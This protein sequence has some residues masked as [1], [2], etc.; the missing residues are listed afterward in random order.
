LKWQRMISREGGFSLWIPAGIYT[1]EIKSVPITD[2][3]LKFQVL[4]TNQ[5]N[6]RFIVA[7]SNMLPLTALTNFDQLFEKIVSYI[8]AKTD[9]RVTRDSLKKSKDYPGYSVILASPDETIYLQ[10]YLANN[11]AFILGVN[12][13]SASDLSQVSQRFFESFKVF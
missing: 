3:T 9:F 11:R 4:S 5:P 10:L 7:Y 6:S 1:D 12:Q 2:V 13:K 8:I